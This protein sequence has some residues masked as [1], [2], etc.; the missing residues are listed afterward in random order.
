L[1]HEKRIFELEIEIE[2]FNEHSERA[3]IKIIIIL[4]D[5]FRNLEAE[6]KKLDD[7]I[8][9]RDRIITSLAKVPSLATLTRHYP[10][11]SVSQQNE[12]IT[13]TI[14]FCKNNLTLFNSLQPNHIMSRSYEEEETDIQ[15]PI[16]YT[17]GVERPVWTRIAT[18]YNV[19]YQCLLTRANGR[20]DRFQNGRYNK[21][22]F[23]K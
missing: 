6:N 10:Q 20:E 21:A 3:K 12:N 18:L 2:N 22:L 11:G 15:R 4:N 1:D 19:P 23:I 5:R 8:K 7:I 14:I 16:L 9:N 17:E 13:K